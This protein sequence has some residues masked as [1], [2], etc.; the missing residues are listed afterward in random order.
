MQSVV[1][2]RWCRVGSLAN[3]AR[4]DGPLLDI[5][6]RTERL[7]A[8]FLDTQRHIRRDGADA[9][10]LAGVQA[11]LNTI[12]T[13]TTGLATAANLA[14]FGVGVS[15]LLGIAGPQSKCQANPAMTWF[16]SSV[17]SRLTL[18]LL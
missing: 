2:W 14:N 18:Y 15:W 10:N 1:G 7:N 17:D 8:K 16:V 5:G 13:N 12:T 3:P 6:R 11:S 4:D 9:P